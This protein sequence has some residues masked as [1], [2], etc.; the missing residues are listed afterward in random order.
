M[1]VVA[2]EEEEQE[3]DLLAVRG[4]SSKGGVSTAL[5]EEEQELG[6]RRGPE[7]GVISGVNLISRYYLI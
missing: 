4:A 7:E 6:R 2:R 5:E 1:D 3:V